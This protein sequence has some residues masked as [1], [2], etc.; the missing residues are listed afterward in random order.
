MCYQA[1]LIHC[2]QLLKQGIYLIV[3]TRVAVTS[4]QFSGAIVYVL[5]AQ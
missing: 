1:L 3:V 5:M 4:H 2:N